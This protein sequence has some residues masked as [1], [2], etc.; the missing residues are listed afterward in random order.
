M[1]KSKW[2]QY[3]KKHMKKCMKK[4]THS[5]CMKKLSIAYKKKYS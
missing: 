5:Q 4:H 3:L 2:T 1:T